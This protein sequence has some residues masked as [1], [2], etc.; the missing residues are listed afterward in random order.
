MKKTGRLHIRTSPE[1]AEQIKDYVDQH[2]T[3]LTEL[4]EACFKK[5]LAEEPVNRM[6]KLGFG[7]G[8]CNTKK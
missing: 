2:G 3:T 8:Q 6:K 5:L 1:L 4:V 7:G